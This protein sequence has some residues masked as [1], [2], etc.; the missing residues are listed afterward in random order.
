MHRDRGVD[1][2]R[3]DNFDHR[4][5]IAIRIG[6]GGGS[7]MDPADEPREAPEAHGRAGNQFD[8]VAGEPQRRDG[9]AR[10]QAGALPP[11]K[12]WLLGWHWEVAP[13]RRLGW[14]EREN[15]A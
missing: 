10:R 3:F 12:F 5:Q 7:T 14:A 15:K 6:A 4:G 1:I 11:K 8:P 2:F 13:A 9:L